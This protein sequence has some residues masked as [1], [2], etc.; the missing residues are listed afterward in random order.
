MPDYNAD[1]FEQ[2]IVELDSGQS[3]AVI[4]NID[5][6]Q[7]NGTFEAAMVNWYVRTSDF[8]AKSLCDYIMS[9]H[10]YGVLAITD[11]ELQEFM[12]AQP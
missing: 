12:E 5:T 1:D 6:V 3:F 7:G 8:T 9:K 4:T 11:D 2:K 10:V